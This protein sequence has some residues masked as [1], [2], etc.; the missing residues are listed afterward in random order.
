MSAITEGTVFYF[1]NS[2][3]AV[4]V[5]ILDASNGIYYCVY[6]QNGIK[7]VVQEFKYAN[8]KWIVSNESGRQIRPSEWASHVRKLI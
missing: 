5:K 8:G 1:G 3:K 4:A 7:W 2:Q 6:H